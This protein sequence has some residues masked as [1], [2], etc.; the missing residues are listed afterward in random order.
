M[1]EHIYSAFCLPFVNVVFECDLCVDSCGG[2]LMSCHKKKRNDLS[3]PLL[4][5]SCVKGINPSGSFKQATIKG[6]GEPCVS[7]Y[8]CGA[9]VH[10][11]SMHL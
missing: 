8:G 11:H 9:V 4:W 7:I 10:F 1:F 3:P 5:P 2:Q 6:C